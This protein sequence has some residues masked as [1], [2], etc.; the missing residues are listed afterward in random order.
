[1][2]KFKLEP[3]QFSIINDKDERIIEP[4]YFTI[5]VGGKQPGFTGMADAATTQVVTGRI[6]VTGKAF[7]FATK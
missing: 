2:V 7:G 6:K 5:A 4:G 3:R 1:V